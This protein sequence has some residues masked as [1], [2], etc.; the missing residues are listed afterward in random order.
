MNACV[1]HFVL[2]LFQFFAL[3]FDMLPQQTNY[4]KLPS[5]AARPFGWS[6][7]FPSYAVGTVDSSKSFSPSVSSMF[8]SMTKAYSL[9]F[10]FGRQ[11]T[12]TQV[13]T[14]T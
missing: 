9:A 13:K 7:S 2:A 3:I 6:G 4:V 5:S 1:Q 11:R 10:G 12:A 14:N 8:N